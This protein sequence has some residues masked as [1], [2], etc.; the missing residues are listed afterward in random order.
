M[1]LWEGFGR[2]GMFYRLH[3]VVY[4]RVDAEPA[5]FPCGI[6][7]ACMGLSLMLMS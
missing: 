4:L 3:N 5:T 2:G 6:S 7:S 1:L